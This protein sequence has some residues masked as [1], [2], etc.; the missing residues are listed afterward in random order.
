[1]AGIDSII[2]NGYK[3]VPD[4]MGGLRI[5]VGQGVFGEASIKEIV[6]EVRKLPADCKK[7]VSSAIKEAQTQVI[8]AAY[9]EA[10]KIY[11]VKQSS[12]KKRTKVKTR[13][14]LSGAN[15]VAEIIYSGSKIPL[16]EFDVLNP[17]RKSNKHSGAIARRVMRDHERR[18]IPRAF[19]ATM[20]ES[21]HEG[22]FRRVGKPRLP[23]KEL[24]GLASSQMLQKKE[25]LEEIDEIVLEAF[26]YGIQVRETDIEDILYRHGY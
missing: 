5:E 10:V 11:D 22:I 16:A 4:G 2:Y 14:S 3:Y 7:I 18:P 19:F 21:E 17:A 20:P 6:E 26:E 24:Y 12:L 15:L 8:K 1:M 25:V 23:I 9:N 13:S